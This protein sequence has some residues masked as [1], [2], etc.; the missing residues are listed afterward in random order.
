[1]AGK[2]VLIL[3][4]D[5]LLQS[6]LADRLRRA[7]YDVRD[8]ALATAGSVPEDAVIVILLSPKQDITPG[9]EQALRSYLRERGGKAIVMTDIGADAQPNLGRL[10]EGSNR[11]KA[12]TASR[13]T[14]SEGSSHSRRVAITSAVQAIPGQ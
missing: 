10:L 6:V 2:R 8:L 11:L 5:P 7:F 13:K 9:E 4:D 12:S 1:M 3:E 14:T